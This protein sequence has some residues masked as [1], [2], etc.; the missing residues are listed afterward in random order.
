MTENASL[1]RVLLSAE[2]PVQLSMDGKENV[3]E[4]AECSPHVNS[5]WRMYAHLHVCT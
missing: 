2:Y 4:V 5:T 3:I 1:L